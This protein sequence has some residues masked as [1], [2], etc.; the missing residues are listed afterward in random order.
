[1]AICGA[2]HHG[3]TERRH[4]IVIIIIIIFNPV[5]NNVIAYSIGLVKQAKLVYVVISFNCFRGHLKNYT[6][7]VRRLLMESHSLRYSKLQAEIYELA[8]QR[9]LETTCVFSPVDCW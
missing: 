9:R 6:Q 5:A 4:G 7:A 3:H 2:H 8:V 1:M